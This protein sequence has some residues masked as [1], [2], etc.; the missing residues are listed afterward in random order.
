MNLE[1][2]SMPTAH[3][4]LKDSSLANHD[5]SIERSTCVVDPGVLPILCW[6]LYCHHL[7]YVILVVNKAEKTRCKKP[8]I[9][10]RP[11]VSRMPAARSMQQQSQGK[12][13]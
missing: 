5:C 7:H 8:A 3:Q 4:I 13:P 12:S 6:P 11:T 2:I 9:K 10:G 1:I